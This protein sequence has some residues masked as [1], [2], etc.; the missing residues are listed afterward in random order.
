M[1][2]KS[3]SIDNLENIIELRP[4]LDRVDVNDFSYTGVLEKPKN[5]L[6]QWLYSTLHTGHVILED[7]NSIKNLNDLN[8]QIVTSVKDPGISIQSQNQ[9]V[10]GDNYALVHGVR[11]NEKVDECNSLVLPCFRP[12]L[13]PGFFMFV[14]TQNGIHSAPIKRHYIYADSPLYGIPLWAQCIE[15]LIAE[16]IDFSAK[17]LSS[18]NNYPR[19]DALVFYSGK[20]YLKVERILTQKVQENPKISNINSILAEKISENLYTAEEPYMTNGIKQSFGE[21]RCN[22]IADAI[23]DHFITSVNFK[24]LLKQRL[25][26]YG[27]DPDDLSKNL[28]K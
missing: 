7:N 19:N 17:V 10:N 26:S 24:L 2:S 21:H 25:I 27:I 18:S 8:Q 3:N 11:I 12:N 9:I 22:A 5:E 13:T 20:D 1:I 6:I 28:A 15:E 14:H 16:N 4:D 23:Q